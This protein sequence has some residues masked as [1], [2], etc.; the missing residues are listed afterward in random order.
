MD[1]L[2]LM[3]TLFLLYSF[4][5]WV[6]ESIYCFIIDK[7]FVNRGFLIGPSLPIY[8]FGSLII[9]FLLGRFIKYPI[10]LFIMTAFVCSVLEYVTSYVMERIFKTRWWDYSEM[11]FNINGRICLRNMM[12]F[13]VLALVMSY[14]INPFVIEVLDMINPVVL[15]VFVIMFFILFVLDVIVSSKIIY[16][17]KGV[18]VTLKDGTEE[19][20]GKVK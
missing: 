2:F 18:G 11:N 4:L 19:I 14:V 13:G 12:L 10:L 8:G 6:V 3:I 16:N 7:K 17:I 20:S 5:G 15:K 9:L 1:K